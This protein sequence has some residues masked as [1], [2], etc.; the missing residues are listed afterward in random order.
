V[1]ET[2]ARLMTRPYVTHLHRAEDDATVASIQACVESHLQALGLNYGYVP[3][4][5]GF[6]VVDEEDVGILI[7]VLPQS[8]HLE[9]NPAMITLLAPLVADVYHPA[10][11]V[12]HRLAELEAGSPLLKL[13]FEPRR[14]RIAAAI[15]LLAD[16]ITADQIASAAR[17]L[18]GTAQHT[19]PLIR[20][21]GGR[22]IEPVR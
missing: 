5:D 14:G 6:L 21:F 12:W 17:V 4:L 7:S 18:W 15:G 1:V 13:G 10:R 2:P 16:E 9:S 22:P 8:E 3:R 11:P 20:D 19:G